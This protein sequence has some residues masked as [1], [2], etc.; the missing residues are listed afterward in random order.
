[1]AILQIKFHEFLSISITDNLV[2]LISGKF[3]KCLLVV[4]RNVPKKLVKQ[5]TS[6]LKRKKKIIYSFI[7]N[8]KNKNQKSVNKIVEILLKNNFHRNDC[9]IS[10]GGGIT[11][12]V[13]GFA[14]SIFKRG[15]KSTCTTFWVI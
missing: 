8:E 6:S 14:S 2:C 11:G 12:D 7:A 4:D 13:S 9:L 5:I 1:M 10:V 3:N 15:I